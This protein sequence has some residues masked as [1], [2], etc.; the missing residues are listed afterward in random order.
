MNNYDQKLNRRLENIK[1]LYDSYPILYNINEKNNQIID[2]QAVL[3]TLYADE[4]IKSQEGICI[5]ILFVIKGTIKIQKINSEGEE[6]NLYNIKQGEFC[7]EALS[8]LSHFESLN[9]T[10]KAVQDS[11]V[12]II[13]IETVR[14]YFMK[15]PEFLSYIY[16]DLH[17]K[18]NT[19]IENKEEIMHE[20]L[21]TRLVKLLVN[22]N[23]SIIY[24]THS[25]LAFEIDSAREVV[26]RKLKDI[27]KRGYIKL[28]RGK[29]LIIKSLNGILK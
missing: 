14:L 22:K 10:G 21:E 20:S 23:S 13:P 4:Y 24:A 3:K 1:A 5:G 7:H 8:C 27:E 18:F 15:D 2:K 29:I 12:C 6:T 19:V 28:E 26:S 17:N 25:Q 16:E 11:E 9:I